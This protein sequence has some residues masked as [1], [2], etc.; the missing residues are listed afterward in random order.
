MNFDDEGD[1][2][3]EFLRRAIR[4][5][6]SREVPTTPTNF[7]LWYASV[8]GGDSNL[9][10]ELEESFPGPGSYQQTISDNMF[11]RYIVE[12]RMPDDKGARDKTTH[13]LDELLSNVQANVEGNR[14]FSESLENGI[15]TLQDTA[16]PNNAEHTLRSL[17][18]ETVKVQDRNASFQAELQRSQNGIQA[19][20]SELAVSQKD[21]N[22]DPLT[23]IGNR[24]HFDR[25]LQEGID[26]TGNQLSVL[27]L[28]ID[29]FKR[30]NDTHGHSTGDRVI[31][32]IA[33]VLKGFEGDDIVVARYGGEE[34]ALVLDDHILDEA[35]AIAE[36]LRRHVEDLQV[37]DDAGQPI[38]NITASLGAAQRKVGES[39]DEIIQRSDLALYQAKDGGRNCVQRSI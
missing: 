23:G 35:I 33:G 8:R 39:A 15:A 4:E 11:H 19:L 36:S 25:A 17:L 9:K 20:R 21:A 7:A 22:T 37:N 13:L 28:D 27:L 16:H 12:P 10:R 34:F 2:A 30:I 18:T 31:T 3:A 6:V 32:A 24:R 29:Y 1:A 5:M 14:D 38:G 26:N